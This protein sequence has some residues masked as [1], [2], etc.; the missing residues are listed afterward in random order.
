M[1]LPS[2]SLE[3][4]KTVLADRYAI[5]RELAR[6]GMSTVYLA[7]DLRHHR[8]VAV[9]LLRPEFTTM[10]DRTVSRGESRSPRS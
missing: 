6:G 9:K 3:R 1:P 10:V 2:E 5:E 7:D 8:K 4:L